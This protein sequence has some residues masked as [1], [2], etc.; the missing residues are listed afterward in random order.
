MGWW[1]WSLPDPEFGIAVPAI[2]NKLLLAMEFA[3]W[4]VQRT[5]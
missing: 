1:H 3:V 5:A 2:P 4:R